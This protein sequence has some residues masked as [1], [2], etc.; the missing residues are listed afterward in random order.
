MYAIIDEYREALSP[1]LCI[2]VGDKVR[3][4]LEKICVCGF[5]MREN[6][7][8]KEERRGERDKRSETL[9]RER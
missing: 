4:S 7:E 1:S 3:A 2:E 9:M 6:G 8:E 5:W